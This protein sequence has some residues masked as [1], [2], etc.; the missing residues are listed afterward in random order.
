M[1]TCNRPCLIISSARSGSKLL[2]ELL[3]QS[4]QF[5]CY[6]Y[7]INYVWKKGNFQRNDDEL[8]VSNFNE[9]NAKYI[10]GYLGK[11]VSGTDCRILE[12][13]VSN[14]LRLEYVLRVL[15][16]AQV[17]HLVRDG[18][19]VTASIHSCWTQPAYS[20]KNQSRKLL[21][22]KLISFPFSEAG[23]YLAKYLKNN[24]KTAFAGG[25]VR[26]WGPRFKGIDEMLAEEPL[27]AVCAE[28]WSRSVALTT[29]V[30]ES[31]LAHDYIE[32]RYEK[33]VSEPSKTIGE[34]SKFLS[35][36]SNS[37]AKM[38]DWAATNFRQSD[39]DWKSKLSDSELDIVLPIL[40]RELT[41]LGYL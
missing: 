8:G 11:L 36:D 20:E 3:M 33:L 17:I 29:S 2:R 18:R 4:E 32:V 25:A 10:R 7:D 6:P 37:E 9:D 16:N 22:E 41:K 19:E 39:G 31:D 24:I 5:R 23:T 34:V 13:T 12:K 27:I 26:S 38:T 40:E 35:L 14:A 21:L 1:N 28:Q 15:P 30:L